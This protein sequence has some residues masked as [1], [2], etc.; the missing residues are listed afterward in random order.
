MLPY[1]Y[2]FKNH[3]FNEEDCISLRKLSEANV[4]Q[5]WGYTSVAEG[6][7]DVADNNTILGP[8]RMK[9]YYDIVTPNVKKVLSTLSVPSYPAFIRHAPG[10][11]VNTHVDDITNKRLTVLSI[12]LWPTT[13]YPPT[14][15]RDTKTGPAVATATFEDM[16]PCLLN[17]RVWHDLVNTSDVYRLNFQICFHLPISKVA[18]MVENNTLWK[19]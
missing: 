5:Y 6:V 12:P 15:F 19:S 11:K 17:T 18:E 3:I 1:F 7:S 10:A 14:F 16:K 9:G 8:K 4:D 13:D 2:Q